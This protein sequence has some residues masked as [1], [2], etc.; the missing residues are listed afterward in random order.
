MKSQIIQTEE[1]MAERFTPEKIHWFRQQMFSWGNQNRRDFPWRKTSDPYAILVAEF[2]LQKNDVETVVPIYES[3][4][5]R[6]PT[7]IPI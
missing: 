4:L 1:K 3:F 6:Y 7:L 2:L 5:F